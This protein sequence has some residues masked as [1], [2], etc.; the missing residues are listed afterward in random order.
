MIGGHADTEDSN[1]FYEFLVACVNKE[2]GR[3]QYNSGNYCNTKVD[4]MIDQANT[5][6]DTAKRAKSID[7]TRINFI[8][9][10]SFAHTILLN[11]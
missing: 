4:A 1:N 11:I 8:V 6:T 2:S 10:Y 9:N 5:E 7:C 3:R